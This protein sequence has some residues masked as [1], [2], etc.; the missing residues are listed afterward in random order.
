MRTSRWKYGVDA[1]HKDPNKDSASD[2]YVE[3]Y[4]YDLQADPRELTSVLDD[5]P[6]VVAELAQFLEAHI[7]EFGPQTK[8]TIHRVID[9]GIDESTYTLPSAF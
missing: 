8:G 2:Y 7:Q 3:Q 5:H 9:D 6:D 1:P 4:L